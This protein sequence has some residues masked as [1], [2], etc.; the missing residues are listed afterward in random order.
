MKVYPT[1]SLRNIALMSHQGAGK[2][3]LVEAMLFN[4]GAI[5]RLGDV[6]EGSTVADFDEEEIRRGLS[7][8]TAL[9]A[10][11]THDLKLNI[12]DTPGY[13]DFQGEVKNALRISDLALLV[14]DV[15]SGVEVGSELYWSY[16][17]E[18]NLPRAV[19][20]NKM[21]RENIQPDAVLQQL[22]EI[23]D[24]RFV[25]LQLPIM[26]AGNFAGVVDLLSM[27]A[28]IGAES[29]PQDIP[30][31]L[32][33]Q[34]EEARFE[35]VEAAAESDDTLLEKYFDTGE[36]T[37]EEVLQGV[38]AGVKTQSF[39]PVMYSAGKANVGVSALVDLLARISPAPDERPVAIKGEQNGE[40]IELP[41]ADGGPLVVYVFKTT[42]DPFVGRLTYFRVV[43]GTLKADSRY[44]NHNKGE[45]ERVGSLLVLRGKEQITLDT[46]H[47]GDVG[48]V[49]KLNHTVTG[50]TLGDKGKAV[51][52]PE[53][54]F[55]QP[56]YGVAVTP[57]T[58]ADS[59]KMGPTLT[60]LCDEDPTLVWRQD[61]ATREAVLEG[62]GD[63]HV[64]VAIKR[65]AQL[66]A[67][68]ETAIPKVP[69]KETV[70]KT[71]AT[72][73]RHKKQSGGA[74]QFAEVH[75]RVEPLETGAGFEFA[76]EVFGGAISGSYIPSI[77]K[78]I[79]GVMQTGVIAGYPVVDVKAVVF[80][81]KEH[82]VDSKDI[83]FQIAGR[84]VFKLAF[85]GASPVLLEP[86]VNIHITVPDSNMG[87]VIG[88]LSSRRGQVQ[89]TDSLVGKA[90]VHATVPLA[91]VQRYSNDLR[92][93]TQGRG[94]YTMELSHF[95]PVPSHIA[96][97]I[98]AKSQKEEEE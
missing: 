81:G 16:A 52:L 38:I 37:D 23:F 11:E 3:S 13:V 77:E 2:T 1:K 86:I 69:Y 9:V 27:K 53:L 63:V 92:S 65:A 21:D 89:G 90:I 60:R 75:L 36:L 76:N 71:F 74:G 82:P 32:A 47:A 48:A 94:V 5:N 39:V 15:S 14:I 79:K 68:L 29:K 80:D 55:P 70:T 54:E 57:A 93:F 45:E 30:A 88:D 40:E 95:Q 28:F 98:I 72:Q 59:A 51:T 66:G 43:S 44:F 22:G 42:A 46:M 17:D 85:K 12:L 41:A 97:E 7:L 91:E 35:L 87:D 19:V 26:E 18:F 34:A 4:T 73:Y 84:E 78:G 96:E 20:I 33:D 31:A 49:A 8:S 56:I 62:M 61:P 67:N 58:Q 83:A 50:D 25:R 6:Q 64:D 24:A 10:V